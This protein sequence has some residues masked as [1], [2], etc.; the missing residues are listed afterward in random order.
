MTTSR[1]NLYPATCDPMWSHTAHRRELRAMFLAHRR[2]P[3]DAR[4]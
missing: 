4:P 2:S 1:I 3:G